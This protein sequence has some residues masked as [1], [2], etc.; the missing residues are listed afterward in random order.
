ME[1]ER[2]AE[3]GVIDL[4]YRFD[5][6]LVATNEPFF[7]RAEDYEAHDALLAIAEGRLLSTDDRRRLTPEHHFATRAEMMRRFADLPE[8][9]EK[10]R[11]NCD[12]LPHAAAYRAAD[13][14][15]LRL[16][17]G[18]CRSRRAG[19]RRLSF[20]ARPQKA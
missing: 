20:A 6:P 13:P 16:H 12:A 19:R 14:A 18:G 7:P 15:A 5:L 10:H 1:I 4:A 11:R 9:L 17:G 8:A 2:Q 3:A